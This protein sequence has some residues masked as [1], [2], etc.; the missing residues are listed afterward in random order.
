VAIDLIIFDCDGVLVDSE[1]IACR[2]HAAVLTRYGYPITSD[3]VF[4]RFLGR[5]ARQAH[6]EVEAELGCALPDQYHTAL[7]DEL[8]RTFEI[9]LEAI[10]GIHETLDQIMLSTCVAS[11]GSHQR[12]RISLGRARLYERFAPNIFSSSEVANGKPAPDLFLFAAEKMKTKPERCLVVEDSVSG[13]TAARAAGMTVLGFCGGSHCRDGHAATLRA[14]GAH[15]IFS[16]MRQ[17]PA[18]IAR[19]R[20]LIAGFSAP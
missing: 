19:N 13:I 1:T 11:S 9:E 17:L 12:M 2:T 5:S 15:E 3:Q 14:A 7:Q 4:D 6:A 20:T 10:A 16:D 8:Y 18:L